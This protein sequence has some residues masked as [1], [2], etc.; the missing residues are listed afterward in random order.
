MLLIELF[1][2]TAITPAA[3]EYERNE[4]TAEYQLKEIRLSWDDFVTLVSGVLK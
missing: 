1:R 4:I 3:V 2:Q